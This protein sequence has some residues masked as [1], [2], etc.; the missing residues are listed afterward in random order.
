MRSLFFFLC[1]VNSRALSSFLVLIFFLC[2]SCKEDHRR[3]PDSESLDERIF[4]TKRNIY[5]AMRCRD[6]KCLFLAIW[7]FDGTMLKGDCSEGLTIDGQEVYKGLA[8]LAYQ[9]RLVHSRQFPSFQILFAHYQRLE[10]TDR[11]A[12]YTLLS[13]L[14]KGNSVEKVR[15]FS[16][17]YFKTIYREYYFK[18]SI[19]T[20]KKLR[21]SGIRSFLVSASAD[22]YVEGAASST[23]IPRERI[24]GIESEI[25]N[26][27]ITDRPAR[28]IPYAD[29][30]T[31][32]VRRIE[33]HYAAQGYTVILLA[34]F[35]N[36]YRTDGDFLRYIA[37]KNYPGGRAISV[38]INGG[39][40][41]K[42]YRG[43]FIRVERSRTVKDG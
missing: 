37:H 38:M 12:A 8:E 9:E 16:D 32:I 2:L 26:G 33:R 34:G 7:D 36:S 3:D 4:E 28:P 27:I 10:K 43:Y 40:E 5:D 39:E 21:R 25:S 35:G 42:E 31:E 6:R 11:I 41:P 19:E 23:G 18:D 14:L 15:R 17:K 30:K 1:R 24:Y 20:L 29:G 13:G 22:P